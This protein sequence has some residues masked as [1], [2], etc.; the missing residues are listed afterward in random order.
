M[1]IHVVRRALRDRLGEEATEALVE[2]LRQVDEQN[3]AD[4]LVGR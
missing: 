2:F 3:R 1:G 4:L